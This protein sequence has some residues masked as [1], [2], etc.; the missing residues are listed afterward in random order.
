MCPSFSVTGT[1]F[2][3]QFWFGF[4][5]FCFPWE[6]TSAP[7]LTPREHRAFE[8]SLQEQGETVLCCGL[9]HSL[10]GSQACLSGCADRSDPHSHTS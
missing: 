7:T 1:S 5:L 9:S 6:Q 2:R 10:L 4:L 8:M 3:F